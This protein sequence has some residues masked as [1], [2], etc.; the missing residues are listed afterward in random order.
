MKVIANSYKRQLRRL[1]NLTKLIQNPKP[2]YDEWFKYYVKE[3]IPASFR[4]QGRL[5]TGSEW[6]KPSEKY[7]ERKKREGYGDKT[8]IRTGKMKND[9]EK[10]TKHKISKRN[11]RVELTGEKYYTIQQEIRAWFMTREGRP[12]ARA[13]NKLID[14]FEKQIEKEYSK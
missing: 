7:R 9:A 14:L 2:V 12:P 3:I 11:M 6:K 8:L 13:L 5:M 10:N 1:L 4:T